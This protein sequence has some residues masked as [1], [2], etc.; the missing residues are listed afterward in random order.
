MHHKIGTMAAEPNQAFTQKLKEVAAALGIQCA[1]ELPEP[2]KKRTAQEMWNGTLTR[3]HQDMVGKLYDGLKKLAI[4]C[5]DANYKTWPKNQDAL[6]MLGPKENFLLLAKAQY[7]TTP[8]QKSRKSTGGNSNKQDQ[9]RPKRENASERTKA[10]EGFREAQELVRQGKRKEGVA[11][12]KESLELARQAG[13]V[14]E[15]VEILCALALVSSQR[16]NPEEPKHYLEQAESKLD[17]LTSPASKMIY[18]R[19]KARVCHATRNEE[20]EE[21]AY[22]EALNVGRAAGDDSVKNVAV[23][24]CIIR[25][26]LTHLLCEQGRLEEAKQMSDASLVFA[27]AKKMANCWNTPLRQPFIIMSLAQ[28]LTMLSR[29]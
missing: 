26:S 13:D 28:A 21:T 19:A 15:E 29:L 4:G 18:Y 1:S 27:R 23:Q 8:Q 24:T 9:S 22:K 3:E 17:A 5:Q 10:G 11:A 20:G 7:E 2:P 14:V 16:R 12:M 25:G 6:D